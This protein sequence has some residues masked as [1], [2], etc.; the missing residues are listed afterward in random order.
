MFDLT[1]IVSA[2]LIDDG[3]IYFSRRHYVAGDDLGANH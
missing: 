2:E 3:S 1:V